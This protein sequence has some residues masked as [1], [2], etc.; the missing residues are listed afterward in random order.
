MRP[1][2]CKLLSLFFNTKTYPPRRSIELHMAMICGSA[3]AI[4][5]YFRYIMNETAFG[6]KLLSIRSSRK[7]SKGSKTYM[8]SFHGKRAAQRP[9]SQPSD[10]YLIESDLELGGMQS[11][12]FTSVANGNVPAPTDRNAISATHTFYTESVPAVQEKAHL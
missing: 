4:P 6:S 10:G 1:H 5:Q 12:N 3:L 11:R 2:G 9:S 7:S 8:S